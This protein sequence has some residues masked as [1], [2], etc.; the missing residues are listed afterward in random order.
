[1]E[2]TNYSFLQSRNDYMST[3]AERKVTADRIATGKRLENAGED[4]GAIH[5]AAYQE[6]EL[7][8][9]RQS[10]VNL[11]NLRSFLF[12]QEN[13]LKR[14][15]EMYDKMEILSIKSA[16]PMTSKS[17]RKDYEIEYK[18]YQKQLDEIMKSRYNGKLL[19][20]STEMCGGSTD[21][22]LGALDASN[23]D[24]KFH[25]GG[26]TIRSQTVETG[27]PSGKV[28]FRVNSGTAGDNYRIWMGDI[29]VFS[30]GQ[31]FK[32]TSND[33]YAELPNGVL[34][35]KNYNQRKYDG[36]IDDPLDP[37][38]GDLKGTGKTAV[39]E[40]FNYTYTKEVV[41]GY[42]KDG[43]AEKVEKTIDVKVE[44]A[45]S[46]YSGNGWRTSGGA[47]NGDADLIEV[48]F[49]PGEQTTYKIIPGTTNDNGVQANDKSTTENRW[50]G[51][52]WLAP[53]AGDGIS[54]YNQYDL[55]TK[56]YV[57]AAGTNGSTSSF[58]RSDDRGTGVIITNAL[59]DDF[60]RTEM[61][62]QIES[63]SIGVIY[64][65]YDLAQNKNDQNASGVSFNPTPFYREIPKD[66]HGNDILLAPKGFDR[67]DDTDFS[68]STAAKNVNEK[69]RGI[70]NYEDLGE[71]KCIVENRIGSLGAEYKRVDSEIR[72]LENQITHGEMTLGRIKDADMAREAT[73]LARNGLK[74]EL[75]TQVMANSSRLKDVLIQLTTEH[76][77]GA[78][79]SASL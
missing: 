11:K 40:P 21:I 2:L 3:I 77:R 10:I 60:D 31:A 67:F 56:K 36:R 59:P 17:D 53:V 14:V 29:C 44:G 43:N 28:S 66:R 6:T 71:M 61:T 23:D 1:M 35:G 20:S 76:F 8:V 45:W 27:S 55:T 37:D 68:S 13:S 4:V 9:D 65:E 58:S 72:A 18:A 16:N 52:E 50:N 78:A 49:A 47:G 54:D 32:G 24:R 57:T 15:H 73:E 19:F 26:V 39:T 22:A 12:A 33:L 5:Q 79:L 25:S 7:R 41:T 75:A 48:E 51:N 69:M 30:A 64:A 42:D 34:E 62:L 46:D 74:S 63:S 70:G 38:F